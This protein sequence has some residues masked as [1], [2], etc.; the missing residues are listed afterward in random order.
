MTGLQSDRS[1][2]SWIS[3][4]GRQNK[5]NVSKMLRKILDFLER[6]TKLVYYDN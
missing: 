4:K 1:Y 2:E 5:V 6:E 3:G